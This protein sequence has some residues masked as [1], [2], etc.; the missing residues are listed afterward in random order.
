MIDFI[1]DLFMCVCNVQLLG[2]QVVSMLLLKLKVVIVNFFKNEGYIF[3]VK[4]FDQEGKLVFE[5]KFKYFEGCL[6]I[7]IIF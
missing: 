2:K 6:V 7:E 1:V 5:I 3:D 4:I